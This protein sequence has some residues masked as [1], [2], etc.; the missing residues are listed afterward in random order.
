MP[1]M[2]S[3][4]KDFATDQKTTTEMAV[5]QVLMSMMTLFENRSASKP[6]TIRP[7]KAAP[8]V[9]PRIRAPCSGVS[10]IKTA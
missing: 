5:D 3:V 10:P 2:V 7:A 8:L 6:K 9:R 4:A 1:I